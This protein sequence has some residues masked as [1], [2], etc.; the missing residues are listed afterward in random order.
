[1]PAVARDRAGDGWGS[2]Q[3][4]PF[5]FVDN[6]LRLRARRDHGQKKEERQ[7]RSYQS[8]QSNHK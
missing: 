8:K 3:M 5:V 6:A 2:Q 4:I 1:M 7:R